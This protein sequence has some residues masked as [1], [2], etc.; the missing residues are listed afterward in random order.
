MDSEYIKN[1]VGKLLAEGLAEVAE[2]RP[3]NPILYL[4]HWLYN[5]NANVEYEAEVRGWW[6]LVAPLTHV[7]HVSVTISARTPSVLTR[8]SMFMKLESLSE[9]RGHFGSHPQHN[10]HPEFSLLSSG[11]RRRKRR[12]R[13]RR[14]FPFVKR[15]WSNTITLNK[16]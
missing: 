10:L 6:L 5:H 16:P 12:R 2:Q 15:V 8:I 4:A 9:A 14:R 1:H 7:R 11:R 13:R 3:V